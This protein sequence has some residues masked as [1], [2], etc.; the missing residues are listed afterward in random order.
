M[1]RV[2][3]ERRQMVDAPPQY[4]IS[5]DGTPRKWN[6]R[7]KITKDLGGLPTIRVEGGYRLLDEVVCWTFLGPPKR[8]INGMTVVH[9]DLDPFNCSVDNLAWRVD[10][11]WLECVKGAKAHELMRPDHLQVRIPRIPPRHQRRRMV[12]FDD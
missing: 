8:H 11:E 7:L 2:K 12:F 9:F 4:Q 3:A 10:P 6:R 5:A 1:P